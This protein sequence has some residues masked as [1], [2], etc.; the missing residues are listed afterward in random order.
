MKVSII[1]VCFN[2]DKTII[3]T[4]NS[5]L[6]QNYFD[7]EHIIVDGGSNDQTQEIIKKYEHKN[8]KIL[9]EKDTGIYDAM[10]K[11]IK[12]ATGDLVTILNSDD[13]YQSNHV[14][15]DVIEKIKKDYD[16]YD[17]FLGDVVFFKEKNFSY[18]RRFYGSKKF[19]TWMLKIGLMPPH[20]SSFI[21]R[22]VYEKYG[23]YDDSL[24]IA[25][26]FEI[27]LRFLL[28]NK[29]K[30]K[31]IEKIVVRMRMGGA[32]GKNYASYLLSTKEI[33]YSLKKYNLS[34]NIFKILLR[35]PSKIYQF[36]NVFNQ[37]RFNYDFN[38]SN[39]YFKFNLK[40]Y[41][42]INII[43]KISLIPMQKNFILS[44]LNLAFLGFYSKGDI[45]V[46][47]NFFNWPDGIFA[48][49]FNKKIKKIPG[50][51]I[52]K[53]LVLP[54]NIKKI[55]V[56]G[57]LSKKNYDYIKNK[58]K[59]DILHHPLPYGTINDLKNLLPKIHENSLVFITLPTPKQEQLSIELQKKNLNYKIIC[60]GASISIASGEEKAVPAFMEKAGLEFVWR[61]RTD[62]FRR[63][64]RLLISTKFYLRGKK[65]KVYDFWKVN[66]I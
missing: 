10:N 6:S 31:Y 61:L 16:N 21:K 3:E 41:L 57:N 46:T 26:D 9:I 17:I 8:S 13:I 62:T 28:V 5:V 40:N 64:S 14:I 36:I 53:N 51:D 4:L 43:S 23:L 66:I 50:R 22:D 45:K 44:G 20:P 15:S 39:S 42:N 65:N 30:Y 52:V 12:L 19:K 32:S 37:N 56:I 25:S 38:Y 59:L 33:L 63:I 55:Q 11:G 54:E 34:A 47:E 27:F 1:T 18:V 48:K 58:F 35:I 49:L 60:I 7:I 2:S 24:K 29:L